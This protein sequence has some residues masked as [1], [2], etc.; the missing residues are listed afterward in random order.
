MADDSGAFKTN[1]AHSRQI[2]AIRG[3]RGSTV[4]TKPHWLK[5]RFRH[6]RR[7]SRRRF[8]F[9]NAGKPLRYSRTSL[10]RRAPLSAAPRT[11]P[12]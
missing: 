1:P 2:P 3:D 10:I 6:G 11:R 8:F 7:H 12:I 5:K 4:A 9:T